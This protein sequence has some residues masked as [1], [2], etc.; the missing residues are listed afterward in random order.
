MRG[1]HHVVGVLA[2]AGQEAVVFLALQASPM[3]GSLEKSDAPMVCL[4]FSG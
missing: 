2:G 4:L 1:Q 3:C